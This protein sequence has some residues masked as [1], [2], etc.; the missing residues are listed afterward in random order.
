MTTPHPD[1]RVGVAWYAASEWQALRE[2][3]TDPET[4]EATYPDWLT[5]FEKGLRDLAAAGVVAERVELSVAD[6][7]AWCQAQ[8]RPV[9][10][11]ARAAFAAELLRRRHQ[12]KPYP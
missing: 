1:L 4:L 5:V 6:L 3:A 7:R 10:G 8:H 2:V 9:D 12:A 11:P